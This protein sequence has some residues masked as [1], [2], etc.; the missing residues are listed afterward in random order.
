MFTIALMLSG[1]SALPATQARDRGMAMI[2]AGWGFDLL[3]WEAEAVAAKLRALLNQ[4][5]AGL[6]YTEAVSLVRQYLDHAQ[7]IREPREG[8]QS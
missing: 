7:Q 2:V 5:A 4:P 8:D 1:G 3:G 6:T